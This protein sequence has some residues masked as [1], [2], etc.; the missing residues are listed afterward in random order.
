MCACLTIMN[1]IL[2]R[3]YRFWAINVDLYVSFIVTTVLLPPYSPYDP[4]YV[5]RARN[6]FEGFF[7][8]VL[9]ICTT[10]KY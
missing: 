1:Y 3:K 7:I 5:Q 10:Y 6:V 9:V 4:D 2:I 8:I